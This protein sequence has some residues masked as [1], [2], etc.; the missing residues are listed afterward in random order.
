ML[1]KDPAYRRLGAGGHGAFG[2]ASYWAGTDHLLVVV[3]AGYEESYRR[4]LFSDVQALIARKTRLHYVWGFASAA[5]AIGCLLICLSIL[6]SQPFGSLSA[7]SWTA[8]GIL[9]GI[10]L[11][12]IVLVLINWWLGPACLCHLRTAVQLVALPHLTRWRK[13]QKLMAELAPLIMESQ[14]GKQ[15]AE[16]RNV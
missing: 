4:F 9:A 7:A 12:F 10:A 13:A 11:I 2:S 8:L 14:S 3:T 5:L 16:S 15:K 6:N 1:Q